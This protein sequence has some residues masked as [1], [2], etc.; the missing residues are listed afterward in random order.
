MKSRA[1]GLSVRFLRVTIPF[2]TQATGSAMGNTLI[3]ERL[4]G[5]LNA[6]AGKIERK[7]PVARRLI[8]ASGEMVTTVTRG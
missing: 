8:R 5:N 2:G 3:S 6:D 4:M 7:C 1:T